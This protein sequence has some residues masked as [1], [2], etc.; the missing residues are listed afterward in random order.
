M[1]ISL[2]ELVAESSGEYNTAAA[3][4][5]DDKACNVSGFREG[6]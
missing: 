4:I 6:I 5:L 2:I 3:D 1:E